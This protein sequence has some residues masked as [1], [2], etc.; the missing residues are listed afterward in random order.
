[1]TNITK[2]SKKGNVV[3]AASTSLIHRLVKNFYV[4][5]LAV[6]LLVVFTVFFLN[7]KTISSSNIQI[8]FFIGIIPILGYTVYLKSRKKLDT[9]SIAVMIIIVGVLLR[10][11]YTLYTPFTIRQHDV[12]GS[13]FNHLDY[14]RQIADKMSLPDVGYCQAYHPP[15]HHAIS[16]VFYKLGKVIGLNDFYSFRLVQLEMIF[17]NSMTLIYFYKIIKEFKPKKLVTLAALAVFAFFPYNIYF[18]SFLNNDNTMYFFYIVTVYYM[19]RW[20]KN[21]SVKNVVLLGLFM[22][23]TILAK[24]NGIILIPAVFAVFVAAYIRDKAGA[25]SIVKQAGIFLLVSVPLS[26]SYSLRNLVLFNQGL[27]Y[28][29]EV[30]FE[31]YANT[32]KN[33]FYIPIQGFKTQPFTQDPFTGRSELFADYVL[34]SSLFG[35][36]RFNG[37]ESI[38]TALLISTSVLIIILAAYLIVQNKKLLNGYGF[39]FLLCL[40]LPF[41]LLF[42]SRLSNPVVCGQNFRY[43]GVGLI[44]AAF[45][46]GHAVNKF[47]NSRF[48]FMKYVLAFITVAFCLISAIFVLK[49]GTASPEAYQF[50]FN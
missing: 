21:K 19:I 29:P 49:I 5:I 30:N 8:S 43:A 23:L 6:F 4:P 12:I 34:K 22:S 2:E 32:L 15:L 38:A 39:I 46:Y 26:I 1:M 48:K 37:L 24:K 36:W 18:A 27:M 14:I 47:S 16:A 28:V 17:L 50:N 11:V 35:E 9:D 10:V 13:S 41:A 20:M 25:K 7:D 3:K 44:S 31:K 40:V 42:Q 45:F 33:L